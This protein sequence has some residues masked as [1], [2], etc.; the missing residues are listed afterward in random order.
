[1]LVAALN[2]SIIVLEIP[3][4]MTHKVV[5]KSISFFYSK[6]WSTD[7]ELE[8]FC[9]A[10]FQVQRVFCDGNLKYFLIPTE[11]AGPQIY[12][13]IYFGIT[14]VLRNT[15]PVVI[16]CIGTCLLVHFI[17]K[18][19]QIRKLALAEGPAAYRGKE[20]QL[21]D[22]TI[23]LIALAATFACLIVPSS[24]FSLLLYINF[25]NCSVYKG[26]MWMVCFIFLNSSLNFV[27]YYWKLPPFRKTAN[28]LLSMCPTGKDTSSEKQMVQHVS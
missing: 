17:Q 28:Q 23:C 19:K 24:M 13:R 25:T 2:V 10:A 18:K 15:T 27:I 8:N 3:A 16:T 12:R 1:M 5:N 4:W 14:V 22:L 26:I 6:E 11:F 21:D 9:F 20:K 7:L